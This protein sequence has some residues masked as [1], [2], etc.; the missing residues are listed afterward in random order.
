LQND[1]QLAL[2]DQGTGQLEQAEAEIG[3]ALVAGPEAFECV[4]PAKPRSTTGRCLPRP[5]PWATARRAMCG[6][7]PQADAVA[8]A[9]IRDL[10]DEP[11]LGLL[12]AVG[13]PE[14]DVQCCLFA[15]LSGDVRRRVSRGAPFRPV[16]SADSS[17]RPV[18]MR[19]T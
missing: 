9:G 2:A 4:Q 14:L 15:V 10:S 3:P 7:M 12:R 5:E 16:L 19:L 1:G 17:I 11:S 8:E 18:H 6:V 13:V